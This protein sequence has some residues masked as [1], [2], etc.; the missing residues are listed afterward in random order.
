MKGTGRDQLNEEMAKIDEAIDHLEDGILVVLK[1]HLFSET[2]LEQIISARLP[3]AEKLLMPGYFSYSQKLM[4]VD[5]F[6]LVDE[7]IINVLKNL[8]KVR[9]ICSHELG[10]TIQEQDVIRIGSPLGKRFISY[11]NKGYDHIVE[12]KLVLYYVFGFLSSCRDVASEE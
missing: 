5:S 2:M 11:K 8:N 7:N 10:K 3:K 6:N 4:L 12:L 1:G 9:N